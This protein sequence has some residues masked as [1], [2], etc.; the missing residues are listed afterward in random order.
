LG[1]VIT[2]MVAETP[3]L[4]T[5]LEVLDTLSHKFGVICFSADP[6]H[7]LMWAHYASSHKGLVLE[8]D[9]ADPV[10]N[11]DSFLKVDYDA[12]RAE[13]DPTGSNPRGAVELFAKRK[14]LDW[15]YEQE[16]RLILDLSLA[17]KQVNGGQVIYLFKIEPK[18]LKSV[19][20]GLRATAPTRDE[21]MSL[22]SKAP[23]DHLEVFQIEADQHNFKLHRRRIK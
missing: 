2:T 11:L 14:S 17:R 4:D 13:Y 20:I 1:K 5:Q 3:K 22:T 6:A 9:Q 18:L 8:F 19:T 23:L 12:V 7:L 21:I 15:E 16:F 10:F